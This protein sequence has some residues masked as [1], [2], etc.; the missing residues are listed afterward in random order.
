MTELGYGFYSRYMHPVIGRSICSEKPIPRIETSVWGCDQDEYEYVPTTWTPQAYVNIFAK[1]KARDRKY[2]L[3]DD[4]F[5]VALQKLDHE[6]EPIRGCWRKSYEV[7]T[8]NSKSNPGYPWRLTYDCEDA[9]REDYGYAPVYS[10]AENRNRPLWYSF[11]KKEMLKKSKVEEDD[12]RM[13]L[14]PPWEFKR[15]Q[16]SFDENQ[17]ERMKENTLTKECQVGWCPFLRGLDLRLRSIASGRDTFCTVDYTRYDGTIP[18]DVLEMVREMRADRL[19]LEDEERDLLNWVNINLLDKVVLLAN[20]R[21]V[22]ITGGNPSGQVSTSIDNC[23][24]NTFISAACNAQWY[25]EQKGEVPTLATLERWFDQMVYGDDRISAYDTSIC[26][27]PPVAWLVQ[28]FAD[29]FGMWVK[30][31]KVQYS[32][33]FEGLEFCGAK[34]HLDTATDCWVGRYNSDKIRAGICNPVKPAENEEV[35]KAKLTSARILCAFDKNTIAWINRKERELEDVT[36]VS[37]KG[38][39]TQEAKKMWTDQKDFEEIAQ[40]FV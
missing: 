29:Y 3:D 5:S 26:S 20:G 31:E 10:M 28:F 33:T 36:P 40:L 18:I 16:A 17:N 22:K 39:T 13:I 8:A 4:V 34:M 24:V 38:L 32:H 15:I 14:C 25:K 35:L 7:T 19:E 21:I 23:F 1:F 9:V 11:L 6:M 30:P 37:F 27:P 12:I 2:Q